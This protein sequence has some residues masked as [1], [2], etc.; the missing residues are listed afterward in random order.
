M[1]STILN[2]GDTFVFIASTCTS[3]TSSV[4]GFGWIVIPSTITIACGLLSSSFDEL[5]IDDNEK[6]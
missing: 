4:T 3:L 2:L 5:I 6:R 1:L